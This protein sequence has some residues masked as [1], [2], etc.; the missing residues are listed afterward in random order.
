M[1]RLGI[2]GSGARLR[3]VLPK[4]D[5]ETIRA[6]RMSVTACEDAL[7]EVSDTLGTADRLVPTIAFG[8]ANMPAYVTYRVRV[9][10][11]WTVVGARS[12]FLHRQRWNRDTGACVIDDTLDPRLNGRASEVPGAVEKYATCPP[13]DDQLSEANV[14]EFAP[15]SARFENPSFALNVFPGCTNADDKSIVAAPSQQDTTF[16]FT[17]TGPQGGSSLSISN[18]L[19]LTRVPLLDFRRQQVQLDTSANRA[20]ILQMRLGDPQVIV[21]FE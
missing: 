16:S 18:S 8:T 4:L 10:D 13:A 11:A 3:P 17:V 21:T 1:N 9:A 14:T 20:A 19:L 7:Q 15:E 2:D 12:G 5:R 6:A